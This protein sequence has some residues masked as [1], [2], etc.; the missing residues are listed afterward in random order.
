MILI[1][2]DVRK[3]NLR[4]MIYGILIEMAKAP[5]KNRGMEGR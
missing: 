3:G 5:I 2:F 1:A 4:A